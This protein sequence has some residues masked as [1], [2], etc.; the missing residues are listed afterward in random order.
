MRTADGQL[1]LIDFGIARYF[2]PGQARDT[3]ALG[4]PGFAAPEQYGKAQTTPR[5]DIYSLG[6][7]LHSMLSGNDPAENPF[8]FDP[9]DSLPP[10]MRTLNC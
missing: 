10:P 7:M 8:H 2:K 4:S 6:V 3:I 5:A 1:F 9:L